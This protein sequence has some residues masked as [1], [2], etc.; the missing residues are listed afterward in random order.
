MNRKRTCY[1]SIDAIMMGQNGDDSTVYRSGG[2]YEMAVVNK[3]SDS[4]TQ[5]NDIS[6]KRHVV[7]L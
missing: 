7:S 2:T 1:E 5:K 3:Y 4:T 6:F